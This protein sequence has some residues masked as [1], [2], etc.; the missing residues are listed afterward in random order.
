M[1]IDI[2]LVSFLSTLNKIKHNIHLVFLFATLNKYLR[3]YINLLPL[4]CIQSTSGQPRV[5]VSDSICI[6]DN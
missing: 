6:L 3:M 4:T 1:S 5:R 2:A